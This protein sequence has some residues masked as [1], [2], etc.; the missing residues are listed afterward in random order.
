MDA[1]GDND[2]LRA[3]VRALQMQAA[4]ELSTARLLVGISSG[5]SLAA[6]LSMIVCFIVFQESRRC[7]RRLLFCLHVADAGAAVAWLLVFALPAPRLGDANN[8][9]VDDPSDHWPLLCYAQAHMLLFFLLASCLWT[10]CFASHLFQLLGR[11]RKAPEL[12][13]SRYHLIAWGLP[14]LTVLHIATQQLLGFDLVGPSGL[15]W[16]WIRSWSGF[17]WAKS[18]VDVQL[19]VF[20][21]PLL[22]ILVHNLATY[23]ALLYKLQSDEISTTMEA[24]ICSRMVA[25]GCA[26]IFAFVWGFGLLLY[27]T[28]TPEHELNR[29]LLYLTC[30][31]TPLHG[32]MNALAYGVNQ[33]V[34]PAT[35]GTESLALCHA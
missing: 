23:L 29:A 5:I 16:C 2:A 19:S 31:F 8:A 33:K 10:A 20:Y 24:R 18:G 9:P 15:P 4:S 11:R 28:V 1:N 27:Q 22:A 14:L 6:A 25:Y 34:P 7:G 3:S 26:F 35:S 17:E 21:G 12:Y 30:I 32:A 13:E